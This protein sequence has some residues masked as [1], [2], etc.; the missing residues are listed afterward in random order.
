[1]KSRLP[2]PFL[3]GDNQINFSLGEFQLI[4]TNQEKEKY[5]LNSL[6]Y[7]LSFFEKNSTNRQK[8][9]P[10]VYQ[11]FNDFAELISEYFSLLMPNEFDSIIK[12][13]LIE[14]QIFKT[15]PSSSNFLPMIDLIFSNFYQETVTIID[16]QS[17]NFIKSMFS[18]KSFCQSC[19]NIDK[20]SDIMLNLIA[21]SNIAIIEQ[22]KS[23][24]LS[25]ILIE[26]IIS[27]DLTEFSSKTANS[28]PNII[29]HCSAFIIHS[30]SKIHA[31]K[32]VDS[33]KI[34]QMY[35]FEAQLISRIY[36][37][38]R[39]SSI[40]LA[41]LFIENIDQKG[42]FTQAN[43]FFISNPSPNFMPM[44]Y[45]DL[46]KEITDNDK[47]FNPIIFENLKKIYQN[48]HFAQFEDLRVAVI[49][50]F[51]NYDD[52]FYEAFFTNPVKFHIFDWLDNSVLRSSILFKSLSVFLIHCVDSNIDFLYTF[53][54]VLIDLISQPYKT[55]IVYQDIFEFFMNLFILLDDYDRKQFG[56]SSER[57]ARKPS[58]CFDLSFFL[59]KVFYEPP[60]EYV[61]VFLNH[62][63]SFRQ[64]LFEITSRGRE[65]YRKS[66]KSTIIKYTN[67]HGQ[68]KINP[69]QY[70]I[71]LHE[72]LF[73]EMFFDRILSLMNYGSNKGSLQDYFLSIYQN[74]FGK[75]LLLYFFSKIDMPEIQII[76]CYFAYES[77]DLFIQ[78][79]ITHNLLDPI[80]HKKLTEENG[81][82][83]LHVINILV[84]KTHNHFFDEFVISN[85]NA[86]SPLF[87]L[88][89]ESIKSFVLPDSNNKPIPIPSLI[90]LINLTNME[91]KYPYDHYLLGCYSLPIYKLLNK[92]IPSIV[93][94]NDIFH[95]FI[96]FEDIFYIFEKDIQSCS[97]LINTKSP[98]PFP[99]TF[100]E[101]LP[102]ERAAFFS[103]NSNSS[104]MAFQIRI[105]TIS[106]SLMPLF[107]SNDGPILYIKDRCLLDYSQ[108]KI[109]YFSLGTWFTISLQYNKGQNIVS[110]YLNSNLIK[111]YQS[112]SFK[113]ETIGS[114]NQ[115]VPIHYYLKNTIAITSNPAQLD[116]SE[117]NFSKY[118]KPNGRALLVLY[119][120]FYSLFHTQLSY[121]KL[122]NFLEKTEAIYPT[123]TDMKNSINLSIPFSTNKTK[124]KLKSK[125]HEKASFVICLICNLFEFKGA[126]SKWIINR[127]KYG[128]YKNIELCEPYYLT[129]L[130]YTIISRKDEK[131]RTKLFTAFFC[132]FFFWS[133]L[134][135]KTIGQCFDFLNGY[136]TDISKVF[137]CQYLGKKNIIKFVLD[138][139]YFY[140]NSF[141]LNGLTYFLQL[142]CMALD[143]NIVAINLSN[144]SMISRTLN[145]KSQFIFYQNVIN[146]LEGKI[147]GL[148]LE[149]EKNRGIKIFDL[150]QQLIFAL[151]LKK[152]IAFP[153]VMRA[154]QFCIDN[155]DQFIQQKQSLLC[156][157][158]ARFSTNTQMWQKLFQLLTNDLSYSI[159]LN[160]PNRIKPNQPN[161][162]NEQIANGN[163]RN[164]V[165]PL[166]FSA[167][168]PLFNEESRFAINIQTK[169]VELFCK[170]QNNLLFLISKNSNLSIFYNFLKGEVF[171]HDSLFISN[172]K[173]E[174]YLTFVDK[175]TFHLNLN[176]KLNNS[177]YQNNSHL[178]AS[179]L[180][181]QSNNYKRFAQILNLAAS[182][183]ALFLIETLIALFVDQD[184]TNFNSQELIL[185]NDASL[186]SLFHVLNIEKR[187]ELSNTLFI[188]CVKK[189][190]RIGCFINFFA[191]GYH[192][193]SIDVQMRHFIIFEKYFDLQQPKT[194]NS[195]IPFLY[196][197]LC[198]DLTPL[199]QLPINQNQKHTSQNK[200]TRLHPIPMNQN[201]TNNPTETQNNQLNRSQIKKE[202][203]MN[204]QNRL[205]NKKPTQSRMVNATGTLFE[206]IPFISQLH[207]LIIAY[208]KT[209]PKDTPLSLFLK[210]DDLTEWIIR[211]PKSPQ[212]QR[213]LAQLQE[214]LENTMGTLNNDV[215]NRFK[216]KNE[217]KVLLPL[218]DSLG[219]ILYQYQLDIIRKSQIF[220]K[221]ILN[222]M[223]TFLRYFEK[224]Y[225][226]Y[227]Y[228]NNCIKSQQMTQNDFKQFAK[229]YHITP[230]YCPGVNPNI[231]I[232]S[233][234]PIL[235]NGH[236]VNESPVVS[237][238]GFEKRAYF[239][240]FSVNQPPISNS[241]DINLN[242]LCRYSGYFEPKNCLEISEAFSNND[243]FMNALNA[244]ELPIEP[245]KHILSF[246]A[247]YGVPQQIY[248]CNLIRQFN[249][250]SSVVFQYHDHFLI[251]TNC[252][253]DGKELFFQDLD[254]SFLQSVY[255][256]EFGHYSLY[257]GHPIIRLYTL[258]IILAYKCTDDTITYSINILSYKNGSFVL[259]FQRENIE[260]LQQMYQTHTLH[261]IQ[262]ECPTNPP[263]ITI[264][265]FN[266]VQCEI[267][268][269]WL[270]GK[271]SNLDYL[272]WLNIFAGRSFDDISSYPVIPRVLTSFENDS[273]INALNTH[274][275]N[276]ELPIPALAE[277]FI[278][279]PPKSN[280]ISITEHEEEEDQEDQLFHSDSNFKC[281]MNDP[282]F[283]TLKMRF[284][285]TKSHN[286]EN[287]SNGS[288]VSSFLIRIPPFFNYSLKFND[289]S[290]DAA[291]RIFSSIEISCGIRKFSTSEL[292]PELFTL[293]EMLRNDLNK[294]EFPSGVSENVLL[295]KWCYLKS[296]PDSYI[297]SFN[298]IQL[299]RRA[300]ECRSVR[301]ELSKWIDLI[302][303]F[304]QLGEEAIN[305]FNVYNIL[306][307]QSSMTQTSSFS[308]FKAQTGFQN[309]L[310]KLRPD[311][312]KNSGQMPM[313]IFKEP[314]P[315]YVSMKTTE[316]NEMN[317]GSLLGNSF[318]SN[319]FA[320]TN[321][322]NHRPSLTNSLH[323]F[324][325]N[326]VVVNYRNKATGSVH[327]DSEKG[328]I[329][330]DTTKSV[331][332]IFNTLFY[333]AINV[334]M[335]NSKTFLAVTLRS[336]IVKIVR[337]SINPKEKN[338]SA[339]TTEAEK[340]V[341]LIHQITFEREYMR[342][343]VI[344]D[345]QFICATYC[346]N[347]L[348]LWSIVNGFII[349]IIPLKNIK[350]IAFDPELDIMY[351]GE[352]NNVHQYSIN[353]E[354]IRSINAQSEDSVESIAIGGFGF[355]YDTRFL[356]VG[357][358]SGKV[359]IYKHNNK[360]LQ[361][362]LVSE[363]DVSNY[364]IVSLYA[365]QNLLIVD[366]ID[367]YSDFFTVL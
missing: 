47:E 218:N 190:E 288:V 103:I 247:I 113:L 359:L 15:I 254:P 85:I 237:L 117:E 28:S 65:S 357:T 57:S 200:T 246:I 282:C 273:F 36:I 89:G 159:S 343:S 56:V 364:P 108:K 189:K 46:L 243:D 320:R 52:S 350:S 60:I 138:L 134:A 42:I 58:A 192:Y 171:D 150:D 235:N 226:S 304:K 333:N 266:I 367:S 328:T 271:I 176:P 272:L 222:N 331:F 62:Y 311:F 154:L 293:P 299:H 248:N 11:S 140:Q 277:A 313:K 144:F 129:S 318:I 115:P 240:S 348:V 223:N 13:L 133:K 186:Y 83:I 163:L 135:E 315:S 305:S 14:Y 365:K 207:Q 123:K 37:T 25:N 280:P 317:P 122:F 66:S 34:Y 157:I 33:S 151:L 68:L 112:N 327:L 294:I 99:F 366:A 300:L 297:S 260:L 197:L 128:L 177:F 145:S 303:G 130:L 72:A 136:I 196:I 146:L 125:Y 349:R 116:F 118:V 347:E 244:L 73:N 211:K 170:N 269:R 242:I 76:L 119:Q 132:D 188:Y 102:S 316:G 330:L 278:P 307:Y 259:S 306:S 175:L 6:N 265:T 203:R 96:R 210:Y 31:H 49:Y 160:Q 338:T 5:L 86:N 174:N 321:E 30:F 245:Q 256:N 90:P 353:G 75:S 39:N 61:W 156:R 44:F 147:V 79:I 149:I 224:S 195:L 308:F 97:S 24:F 257:L 337:L 165:L 234:F 187:N 340:T 276:F 346:T 82:I 236:L 105:E 310:K 232:P 255:L 290:F 101:V 206:R 168:I 274:L 80:L 20:Y 109:Q 173:N 264:S 35:Q 286:T 344:N 92:P 84:T 298:F 319:L 152:D 191:F 18:I 131:V 312:V 93:N 181:C 267:M 3:K 53:I 205:L 213:D 155:S 345:R 178:I 201:Q 354:Y 98:P 275:R 32:V 193:V 351:V 166:F 55:E 183:S 209:T 21:Y 336:S 167:L 194:I 23:L 358:S 88:K 355:S 279:S 252:Q 10:Q 142:L 4:K 289:G 139:I 51:F 341:V 326:E 16:A 41:N 356:A 263:S 172:N 323:G 8:I 335:S 77:T 314:H 258:D 217:N 309:E 161:S 22:I 233:P 78:V 334:T 262:E 143:E 342:F 169:V 110:I 329:T 363:F 352:S 127:Y 295:P 63:R 362:Q 296:E 121:V 27:K 230:F 158:V 2:I 283:D 184:N 302:F 268:E 301:T 253:F 48:E 179:M 214:F 332:I 180:I 227:V 250:I 204:S 182:L 100:Y 38:I 29:L 45:E 216:V 162:N 124:T 219:T 239:H 202:L 71:N 64:I 40:Q 50:F 59:T 220:F 126:T 291:N 360:S 94:L 17:K 285:S 231:M 212:S 153:F 87:T 228:I 339:N 81:P 198:T 1:M 322:S 120:S 111:A 270:Q 70:H 19:V 106:N 284:E 54:Y 95:Q 324:S 215:F 104:F 12:I 221:M 325:T 281:D 185:L 107:I 69:V 67:A 229:S 361:F 238:F 199:I 164:A 225:S 74:S 91:F 43:S 7:F 241:I 9:Q 249:N 114:S 251:L 292:I 148:C 141:L 137:D 208:F 287:V 26:C 261:P